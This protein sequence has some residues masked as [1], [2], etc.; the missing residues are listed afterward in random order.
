M[1]FVWTHML[2]GRSVLKEAFLSTP[3]NPNPFHLGCQGPDFLFFYR[4]LPGQNG[5]Q[6]NQL[7]NRMHQWNCGPFLLDLIQEAKQ[8]PSL[9]EYTL[10]FVTHHLLDRKTHPFIHYRSGYKKYRHQKL[11]VLIDTI[12]AKRLEG[13]QTW[14]TPVYERIHVGST[15]PSE[16]IETFTM[17]ATKHYPEEMNGFPSQAWDEAYRD[18]LRALRLFFDPWGIKTILTL[19]QI[20]PFRYPRSVP[21]KDYLNEKESEWLHPAIPT[22][23][24]KESFWVL[25]QQAHDEGVHLFHKI[26][27]Y[28]KDQITIH[29][30]QDMIGNISYDTG[31]E[32]KAKLNNHV[33]D[34]IV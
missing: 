7:G 15:L 20:S 3:E 25:W 29:S 32:C 28:W 16:W 27:L 10:G 34:P 22:E 26:N 18:M 6:V 33:S 30:L 13:I 12:V 9:K 8:K 2:F 19:G 24:H 17:L 14:R 1:P 23:K 11:E 5:A 21:P 31:K 4:F